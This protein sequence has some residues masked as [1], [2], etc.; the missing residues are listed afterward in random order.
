M[1]KSA[2]PQWGRSILA[3][4]SLARLGKFILVGGSGTL[5]NTG[6]LIVLYQHLHVALVAASALATELAIVNNFL[7][8]NYWTFG[9]RSLS[10]HRFARFNVVSL[11]GQCITTVTLW[12]L[13]SHVGVYYVVANIVG[14]GLALIW[15]F[16]ANVTWTWGPERLDTGPKYSRLEEVVGESAKDV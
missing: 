3:K 8:N 13:V 10:L 6:V 5:V 16:A 9:R 15:N 2:Q 7:W 11:G 4:T 14:I 1:L 12:V